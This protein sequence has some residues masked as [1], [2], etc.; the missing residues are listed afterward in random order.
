MRVPETPSSQQSIGSADPSPKSP[1]QSPTSATGK[2]SCASYG[3]A[4]IPPPPT[5]TR[6]GRIVATLAEVGFGYER[7]AASQSRQVCG[8]PATKPA[9]LTPNANNSFAAWQRLEN[10]YTN[11]AKAFAISR[12]TAYRYL[13]G[14]SHGQNA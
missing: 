11:L 14:H 6:S 10:P 2:S 7:R 4:S 1:V 5:G 13:S 12:A 8:L 3:K 9:K